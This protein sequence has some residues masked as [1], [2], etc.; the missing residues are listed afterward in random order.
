MPEQLGQSFPGEG[1]RVPDGVE[2]LGTAAALLPLQGQL[3]E[4]VGASVGCKA[5][6]SLFPADHMHL[7]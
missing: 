1:V 7:P 3:E 5:D 2:D 6:V 4:Q